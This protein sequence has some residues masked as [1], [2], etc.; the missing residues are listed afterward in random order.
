MY[1]SSLSAS[2]GLMATARWAGIQPAK[3]PPATSMSKAPMVVQKGMMGR[4]KT[5]SS[6]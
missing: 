2:I 6:P 4:V 5:A 1:Y 3:S